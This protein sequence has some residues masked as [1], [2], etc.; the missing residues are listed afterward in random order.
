MAR[1]HYATGNECDVRR[2]EAIIRLCRRATEI[3]PELC[4]RLGAD[5][6]RTDAGALR[7]TAA[8]A[9]TGWRP[10]SRPL[11]LDGNL[12]AAHAVKA[13][14]LSRG[15]PPRRGRRARS[16]SPCVS[17]PESYEVNQCRRLPALPAATAARGR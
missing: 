2:N 4:A 12:A 10:P 9:T 15:R 11:A 14:I 8:T 17:I 6:P 13:R 5:G 7:S 16:R 1:Q 3:D